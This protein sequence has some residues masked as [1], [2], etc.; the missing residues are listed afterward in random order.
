MRYI[1]NLL[2]RQ[3]LWMAQQDPEAILV[4]VDAD[5]AR[6]Y[7]DG[8]S[9]R[10][11]NIDLFREPG[12]EDGFCVDDAETMWRCTPGILK[13]TGEDDYHLKPADGRMAIPIHPNCRGNREDWE[14]GRDMMLMYDQKS[15]ISYDQIL[16]TDTEYRLA[17]PLPRLCDKAHMLVEYLQL[18]QT[19]REMVFAFLTKE[20]TAEEVFEDLR[21]IALCVCKSDHDMSKRP[22]VSGYED[23]FLE[24]TGFNCEEAA[25]DL[26][27]L[28]IL[29]A[30]WEL[31]NQYVQ[32]EEQFDLNQLLDAEACLY[33]PVLAE[34]LERVMPRQ[35]ADG[36]AKCLLS[37]YDN[38]PRAFVKVRFWL[39]ALLETRI[40]L[41]QTVLREI[42]QRHFNHP[43]TAR[44]AHSLRNGLHSSNA[45]VLRSCIER[46]YPEKYAQPD[47]GFP[48]AL[49][50]VRIHGLQYK[51]EV[52]QA[53]AQRILLEG[54]NAEEILLGI[55][56][57]TVYLQFRQESIRSHTDPVVLTRETEV[58]AKVLEWLCRS[59]S[60]FY[61]HA[62]RLA[63]QLYLH[64][65]VAE[66]AFAQPQVVAAACE[67][68]QKKICPFRA[69]MLLSTLPQNM[70]LPQSEALERMRLILGERFDD[71][72]LR[73]NSKER[74]IPLFRCCAVL[75]CWK[76]EFLQHRFGILLKKV[77]S[78][79]KYLDWENREYMRRLKWDMLSTML[80]SPVEAITLPLP[81]EQETWKNATGGAVSDRA[82]AIGLLSSFRKAIC[83]KGQVSREITRYFQCARPELTEPCLITDWFYALCTMGLSQEAYAFY[84]L[85]R[86]I[87]D[88]PW[89]YRPDAMGTSA[90]YPYHD[91]SCFWNG[92]ARWEKGVELAAC[93]GHPVT[94]WT[95][96]QKNMNRAKVSIF[97]LDAPVR[98]PVMRFF[99]MQHDFDRSRNMN[100]WMIH[101]DD[102]QVTRD[103]LMNPANHAT[104]LLFG[105]CGSRDM[106]LTALRADPSHV[107]YASRMLRR[108][109]E[110]AK[111]VLEQSCEYLH[112]LFAPVTRNQEYV[113]KLILGQG[114]PAEL[115]RTKEWVR[116]DKELVIASMAKKPQYFELVSDRLRGDKDVVLAALDGAIKETEGSYWLRC[117][118][119]NVAPEVL[120]APEIMNLLKEHYCRFDR[121][122]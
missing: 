15:P 72:M 29:L 98:E 76:K 115:N 84:L 52:I 92:A 81:L 25:E 111:T 4:P 75:G 99:R 42:C 53:E 3:L 35:E 65:A 104:I 22:Y 85:Y 36:F 100:V 58:A 67:A 13:K 9:S 26:W 119:S 23:G 66:D 31:V 21:Y 74:I 69:E 77:Q 61:P 107:C 89:I 19:N 108:D 17:A 105:Y 55:A 40:S 5:P 79:K 122:E 86:E 49:A 1:R 82:R 68:W 95:L 97:E 2:V 117:I 37:V 16:V 18:D 44:M 93:M 34:C 96:T 38:N 27:I 39:L 106:V 109:D 24:L 78:Q 28:C 91:I 46:L 62:C 41:P 20:E 113:R 121:R 6:L 118:L 112:M 45:E 80:D 63:C 114:K 47:S 83:R 10:L 60:I 94:Q 32:W 57:M 110:V 8:M 120:K 30:V 64:G 43:M 50:V 14:H 11:F 102:P 87:L 59:E 48:V 88:R 54:T 33:H 73:K 103:A 116:N 56:M 90:E 12:E 71:A 70:D 101:Y 7:V 51:S